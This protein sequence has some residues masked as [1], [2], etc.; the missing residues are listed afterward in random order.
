VGGSHPPARIE[1][2]FCFLSLGRLAVDGL[3]QPSW[4]FP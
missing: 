4:H 3:L 2:A 1:F